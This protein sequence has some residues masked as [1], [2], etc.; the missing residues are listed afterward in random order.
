MACISQ[1]CIASDI[2]EVNEN[3]LEMSEAYVLPL[4]VE[5][6]SENCQKSS[7]LNL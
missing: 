4:Q 1:N 6:K 5:L 7:S 3:Y 2:Q